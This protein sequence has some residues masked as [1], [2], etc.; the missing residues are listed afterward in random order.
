MGGKGETLVAEVAIG[1]QFL[2]Q[3]A[4]EKEEKKNV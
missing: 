4:T 3:V 1:T 2:Q